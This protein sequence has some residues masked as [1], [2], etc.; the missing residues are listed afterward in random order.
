MSDVSELA[1]PRRRVV[2]VV[3]P[4]LN[5]AANVPSL[6]V[7]MRQLIDAH[8]EYDFELVLVDDGSSDGTGPL[9]LASAPSGLPTAVVELSRNFGPHQAIT[10]GLRHVSG[11]CAIVLGADAQEPLDLVGDFLRSWTEGYDVVWGV[12]RTRTRRWTSEAPSK[13]FSYAFSRWSNLAAYPAEGP[14]GML[15]DRKVVDDVNA[16]GEHNRNIMALVAWLGYQQTRVAYDQLA[17]ANGRS[18][19]T[20]PKMVKLATDSLLAFSATPL[21]AASLA[22]IVSACVGVIY[23]IALAVRA[24]MGVSTPSGWPTILVVVL[25]LGGVQLTVIGIMGEYVWRIADEVRG[26]PL[27]VVRQVKRSRETV[28]LRSA[29]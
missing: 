8:P 17:R 6:V 23:A 25:L 3:V 16:L 10:A 29:E 27:F 7:R 4:A 14:S 13:F 18:S 11:A 22:G 1:P 12:R 20:V 2:S 24:A 21:R 19:W 15:I 9:L 5:E 26:R 28:A